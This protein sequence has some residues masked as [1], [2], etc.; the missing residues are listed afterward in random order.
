MVSRIDFTNIIRLGH[1]NFVLKV[2]IKG[3]KFVKILII[4][5]KG[6]GGVSTF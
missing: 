6:E 5:E 3:R 2:K 4:L 1:T